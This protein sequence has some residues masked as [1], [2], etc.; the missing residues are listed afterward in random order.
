MQ[1]MLPT[2]RIG[3]QGNHHHQQQQQPKGE[4]LDLDAERKVRTADEMVSERVSHE[5]G[6]RLQL[7]S[8]I[9]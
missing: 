7:L 3:E 4:Q 5:L 2:H 6:G 1:L 9:R 8:F